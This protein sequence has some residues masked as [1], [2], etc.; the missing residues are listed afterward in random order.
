MKEIVIIEKPDSV[1]WEEIR[2]TLIEAHRENLKNG[3]VVRST[4]LTSEQLREQVGDGQC[5]LA[6]DGDELVGVS[7]VRIKQ[8]NQWFCHGKVAHFLLD[9]VIIDYQGRGIYSLLQKARY[10]YVEEKGITIITTNTAE[11][12]KR[13]VSLL[14]KLGFHRAAMF[15]AIDTDHYSIT[16]VKWLSEEP[17]KY[18]RW[19][20]YG[21]SLVKSK[22]RYFIHSLKIKLIHK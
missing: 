15:H 12:N 3:L 10:S 20:R 11:N 16:W 5:F 13:M 8:C 17:C 4:M 2:N 1:S 19:I 22:V 9:S 21:E 18:I 7:A 6:Y 14:P